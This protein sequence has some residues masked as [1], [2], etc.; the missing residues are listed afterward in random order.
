MIKIQKLRKN[1]FIFLALIIVFNLNGCQENI[2]ITE[3][4]TV[5]PIEN[6]IPFNGCLN[7]KGNPGIIKDCTPEFI[8]ISEHS[9]LTA[10]S[11]SGDGEN[12]SEWVGFKEKYDQ[13]N[14][15]SDLHGTSMNSGNKIIYAR[16]KDID[17]NIFPLTFQEP[18]VCEFDY[19]MQNLFSIKIEPDVAEVY[20]GESQ[21]FLVKGYGIFPENEVPL[22]SKKVEWSKPCAAGEFSTI[23]GL[24]TTYVAPQEPGVRNI[25]VHYGVLGAGAKVNVLK[26]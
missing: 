12:W 17:G 18:I 19:E 23:I 8:I 11:F 9:N 24:E 22:Y 14:I 2:I 20:P 1:F 15:A 5:Y 26:K 4:E 3:N 6:N 16:F 25:S 21:K 10:M 7:I 13:F